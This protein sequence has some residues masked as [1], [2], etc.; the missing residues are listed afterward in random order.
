MTVGT[1]CLSAVLARSLA[2][3]FSWAQKMGWLEKMGTEKASDKRSD[4][5]KRAVVGMGKGA[6]NAFRD[7]ANKT[8]ASPP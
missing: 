1:K 5:T 4:T 7:M 2:R 3:S 8:H 6:K